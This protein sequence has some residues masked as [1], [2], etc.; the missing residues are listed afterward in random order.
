MPHLRVAETLPPIPHLAHV[1]RKYRVTAWKGVC[2]QPRDVQPADSPVDDAVGRTSID[3]SGRFTLTTVRPPQD[4][5][6]SKSGY[7]Q[8]KARVGVFSADSTASITVVLPRY[9][10]YGLL[11]GTVSLRV[12]P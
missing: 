1:A 3:V 12:D 2:L 9:V 11:T 4:V 7:Q 5:Q 8:T 6:V 10:R